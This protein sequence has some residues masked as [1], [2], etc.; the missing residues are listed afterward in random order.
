MKPVIDGV[1]AFEQCRDAHAR[2]EQ[3]KNVGKVLLRP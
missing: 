1:Y 2:I 3:G